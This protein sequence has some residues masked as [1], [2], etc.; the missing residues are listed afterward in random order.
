MHREAAP[1][2]TPWHYGTEKLKRELA[3]VDKLIAASRGTGTEATREKTTHPAWER[4]S[5]ALHFEDAAR[6][7]AASPTPDKPAE[8][9]GTAARIWEAY[10]VRS[11]TQQWEERQ[12][13]GTT[14]VRERELRLPG[15]RDPYRFAEALEKNGI[16]LAV[17]T[18]DD[19]DRSYREAE[20]ARAVGNQAQVYREGEFV[21]VNR[22]DEVYRFTGG[23]TGDDPRTVQ[24]FLAKADWKGIQ[25]VEATRQVVRHEI[26]ARQEQRQAR[27]DEIFAAREERATNFNVIERVMQKKD[28]IREVVSIVD[29]GVGLGVRAAAVVFGAAANAFESLIA[30]PRTPTIGEMR[31]INERQVAAGAERD[32]AFEK[33]LYDEEHEYFKG[34]QQEQVQQRQK[35]REYY[36]R[37]KEGGRER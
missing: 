35:E 18:K 5:T 27:S 24:S 2:I 22:H 14:E 9:R 13:D 12:P 23:N 6:I 34:K 10:N 11:W 19:A 29:R 8:L 36:E 21:G 33:F 4:S 31:E 1:E 15:K 37:Q 26:E 3:E 25:S 7:T 16:R 17:V 20:F 32:R 28:N 30:P